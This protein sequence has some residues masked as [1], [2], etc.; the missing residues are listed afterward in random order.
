VFSFHSQDPGIRRKQSL[1]IVEIIQNSSV[2]YGKDA[3][4][5]AKQAVCTIT[6]VHSGVK[7]QCKYGYKSRL[8]NRYVHIT[9]PAHG[10]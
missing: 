5:F 3:A 1:F 2:H 4:F 9:L 8:P 10:E 7:N 6:T